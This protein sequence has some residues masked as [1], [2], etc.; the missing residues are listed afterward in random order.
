MEMLEPE[1]KLRQMLPT[2][3]PVLE[4]S[5]ALHFLP[6]K[7]LSTSHFAYTLSFLGSLQPAESAGP[8]DAKDNLRFHKPLLIKENSG[9]SH[10]KF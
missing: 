5:L 1:P 8:V 7:W 3:V 9:E 2:S 4:L 6:I 10:K